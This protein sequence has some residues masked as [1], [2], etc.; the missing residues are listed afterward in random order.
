[1]GGRPA[2]FQLPYSWAN[3]LMIL[4]GAENMGRLNE[5]GSEELHKMRAHMVDFPELQPIFG[6]AR[7][8]TTWE[9]YAKSGSQKASIFSM[10]YEILW[11]AEFVC[12]ARMYSPVPPSLCH[13]PA[14][15][16]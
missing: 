8:E 7:G 4:F 16:P 3:W 14:N 2:K 1:M 9:A 6:R 5:S 12:S 10:L 11:H 13:G 15:P